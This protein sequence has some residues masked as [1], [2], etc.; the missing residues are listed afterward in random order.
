MS[1]P[2]RVLIVE[3]SDDD[4]IL[5]VREL[6]R[7]GYDVSFERVDSASSMA[8]A[9]DQK[10]WD[11]VVCDYSMPN[12]SGSS[13]LRL[14]RE[15][16][17]ELPFIYLSGTI[18]EETAVSALKQGAQDYLMKDNL[19]RLVPAIQRELR[20]A[21]AL[22]ERKHLQL[23]VQRL[24]K[25][26][27]IGRLAGGIAHDFNNALG[28][29]M[30]WAQL[31]YNE[32]P[33]GSASREK[34]RMIQRQAEQS[35][36]LTSQLLAFARRQVLQPRN[37]N[38]NDLVVTT[39][40][41]LQA[42]IGGQIDFHLNLA[43]D[44]R[45]TSADPTQMQQVLMNLCLNAR[46]A[47][48]GGGHVVVKTENVE[49]DE[50]FCRVH[51]YGRPG[52]YILLT[53]SDNGTGMDTATLERIFEPFF[54][55][56]EMGRGTGLG[57][58]TVYGIVKQHDGFINV[59]SEAGRGTTFRVYLVA[60]NGVPEPPQEVAAPTVASGT[61][62]ILVAED[63]D[64]LRELARLELQARGYRVILAKD[65]NDAVRLFKNRE[66]EI[67]LAILDITMP[68]L[69]GPSAYAQM[70]AIQAKLPAIFTSGHPAESLLLKLSE[71]TMFLQ[72]PYSAQTLSQLV[73]RTLDRDKS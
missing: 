56:K 58:A 14:L 68:K 11:L 12:F 48:P 8:A 18:G 1:V 3:D 60:A 63:N 42:A 15:K 4:T 31:G 10:E 26:E 46:D 2:L 64:A 45:L 73:R 24:Q 54:T 37:L 69:S 36:G 34:F 66:G 38:L 62:T 44:L 17:T 20:E 40:E 53:V 39:N 47:M 41:L 30:G 19:K 67:H 51:S 49:V 71:N 25:Y 23:Q 7:G 50:E 13:A 27:A 32:A 70:A 35:A 9:L 29:I 33:E 6:R 72:K 55:T 61:E 28:V 5:L 65:G 16:N 22:R 57:L 52:S 43:S 21:Q 59:Y